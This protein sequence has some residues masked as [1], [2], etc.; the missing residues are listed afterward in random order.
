VIYLTT[1]SAEDTRELAGALANLARP[2]D[3]ILLAGDLGAGKTTF[4]QGF[5]RSL[6]VTEP[7]TSPTFV[8]VHVHQGR[9]PLVHADAYRLEHLGEVIDLG[10]PELLDEGAVALIEWGDLLAPVLASDFLEVRL[11]MGVNDDERRLALRAVGAGWA[12]RLRSLGS[13]VGRWRITDG[14]W[15]PGGHE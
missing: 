12:A 8:L 14:D 6:G 13:A 7:I 2:G 3:V 4:A 10:L 9:L 5:G 11:E 1:K 15:A